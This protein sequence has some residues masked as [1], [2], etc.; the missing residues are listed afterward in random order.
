MRTLFDYLKNIPDLDHFGKIPLPRTKHQA[1]LR[2]LDMSVPEQF[3]YYIV[4]NSKEKE[5]V[6]QSDQIFE[7]F[8]SWKTNNQVQ[9]EASKIK[10][11]MKLSVLR[12][13][14]FSTEHRRVGNVRVLNIPVL[15]NHFKIVDEINYFK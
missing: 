13:D 9:F 15:K 6:F 12:L 5:L 10:F 8:N 7:L 1:E 14:G 11:G 4:E 2:K 3:L